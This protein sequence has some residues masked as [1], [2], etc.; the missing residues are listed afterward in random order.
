[1]GRGETFSAVSS[2]WVKA[3]MRVSMAKEAFD[4]SSASFP[5][6]RPSSPPPVEEVK[7]TTMATAV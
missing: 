7:T 5:L 6:S 2:I 3:Y 1:M 4:T